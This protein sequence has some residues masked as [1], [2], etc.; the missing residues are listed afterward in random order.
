[1]Y[2]LILAYGIVHPVCNKIDPCQGGVRLKYLGLLVDSCVKGIFRLF[3]ILLKKID[4]TF[5][6]V[7]ESK[8]TRV[9][10]GLDLILT[11]GKG[12]FRLFFRQIDGCKILYGLRGLGLDVKG[13]LILIERPGFFSLNTV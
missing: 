2:L 6:V 5:E 9:F 3:D 7:Q 11:K 4:I 12:L 10:V 13:Q 1:M 8:K